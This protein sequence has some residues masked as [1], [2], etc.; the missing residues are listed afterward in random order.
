MKPFR[1][2]YVGNESFIKR[3]EDVATFLRRNPDAKEVEGMTILLENDEVIAVSDDKVEEYTKSHKGVVPFSEDYYAKHNPKEYKNEME[4]RE[5]KQAWMDEYG[6]SSVEH[7][8]Y[9]DVENARQQAGEEL[10]RQQGRYMYDATTGTGKY[11]SE[12]RFLAGLQKGFGV[13][14]NKFYSAG[15][16]PLGAVFGIAGNYVDSREENSWD[17]ATI[18]QR[19]EI[20]NS[21]NDLSLGEMF[22]PR[23]RL[24]LQAGYN[25]RMR[26]EEGFLG[27]AIGQTIENAAVMALTRQLSAGAAHVG[28][29]G[30]GAILAGKAAEKGKVLSSAWQGAKNA[31]ALGKIGQWVSQQIGLYETFNRASQGR[32]WIEISDRKDLD[33]IDKELIKQAKGWNEQLTEMVEI[34]SINKLERTLG[35]TA[36][37]KG[38]LNKIKGYVGSGL[39]SSITNSMQ[40]FLAQTVE[41]VI[42]RYWKGDIK[43]WEEIK[44]NINEA[45]QIGGIS[46]GS[47]NVV[48]GAIGT[49]QR[50][51]MTEIHIGKDGTGI[52]ARGMTAENAEKYQS[53]AMSYIRGEYVASTPE[54]NA[55]I[56]NLYYDP[57]YVDFAQ[58]NIENKDFNTEMVNEKYARILAMS[59]FGGYAGNQG[60]AIVDLNR[61]LENYKGGIDDE[62]YKT[63]SENISQLEKTLAQE[64]SDGLETKGAEYA[65]LN[66][67][68]MELLAGKLIESTGLTAEDMTKSVDEILAMS[69][70]ISREDVLE[71]MNTML[72][73]SDIAL[74]DFKGLPTRYM[75]AEETYR[76]S[77]LT[78]IAKSLIASQYGNDSEFSV[79]LTEDGEFES[80]EDVGDES[81]VEMT[82]AVSDEPIM[83]SVTAVNDWDVREDVVTELT[84][85]LSGLLI[86]EIY[87]TLREKLENG[88]ITDAEYVSL[89]ESEYKRAYESEEIDKK[90]YNKIKKIINEY[91]K[92][93]EAR[94]AKADS[95][96]QTADSDVAESPA[97]EYVSDEVTEATSDT[98]ETEAPVLSVKDQ[99]KA[100]TQEQNDIKTRK[101]ALQD[102]IKRVEN[103]MSSDDAKILMQEGIENNGKD[104]THALVKRIKNHIKDL[105]E[106]HNQLNREKGSLREAGK[107]N[108]SQQVVD[109]RQSTVD[110]TATESPVVAE[111]TTETPVETPK[112]QKPKPKPKPKSTS[113][114]TDT[115]ETEKTLKHFEDWI[116]T[117]KKKMSKEDYNDFVD[118]LKD[119]RS[120]LDI[121]KNTQDANVKTLQEKALDSALKVINTVMDNMKFDTDSGEQSQATADSRQQTADSNVTESPVVAD[122]P[123]VTPPVE[124]PKTT[125]QKPKQK[126]KAKADSGQQQTVDPNETTAQKKKRLQ[127]WKKT[128]TSG[129]VKTGS[130]DFL[131]RGEINKDLKAMGIKVT[132]N[133]STQQLQEMIDNKLV[134]IENELKSITEQSK[135]AKVTEPK[136]ILN[137]QQKGEVN[138]AK[139]VLQR[140]K[141]FLKERNLDAEYEYD[142]EGLED[143]I[144]KLEDAKA[145]DDIE[146]MIDSLDIEVSNA[147]KIM[148]ENENRRYAMRKG[149]NKVFNESLVSQM[150]FVEDIEG[151]SVLSVLN[152]FVTGFGLQ[153][154]VFDN[155][156]GVD[157]VYGRDNRT[158]YIYKNA[159]NP[160]AWVAKHE[161]GHSIAEF[162]ELN[163]LFKDSPM[164][165]DYHK[166]HFDSVFKLYTGVN[167]RNDGG[168]YLVRDQFRSEDWTR[169]YVN[170]EVWGNFLGD[171]IKRQSFWDYI[172]SQDKNLFVRTWLWAK[173][174]LDVMGDLVK[175]VFKF[176][177]N[178]VKFA[179]EVRKLE[180]VLDTAARKSQRKYGKGIMFSLSPTSNEKARR[181]A[182]VMALGDS[183]AFIDILRKPKDARTKKPY[184]ANVNRTPM[185]N[186]KEYAMSNFRYK[187]NTLTGE[188]KGHIDNHKVYKVAD[189]GMTF[190]FDER[191]LKETSGQSKQYKLDSIFH[192]PTIC[193]GSVYLGSREN[194]KKSE[195]P[196]V[197]RYEY[198][199]NQVLINKGKNKG[200]YLVRLC[201]EV[202][203]NTAL[204]GSIEEQTYF[205][206]YDMYNVTE[207]KDSESHPITGDK[208]PASGDTNSLS[209]IKKTKLAQFCQDF[210]LDNT[211]DTT[212]ES[213]ALPK[214]TKTKEERLMARID[215]AFDTNKEV[216]TRVK[217]LLK[218]IVGDDKGKKMYERLFE[219]MPIE[220]MHDLA[221]AFVKNDFNREEYK[222]IKDSGFLISSI[223]NRMMAEALAKVALDILDDTSL[224]DDDRN[225][226]FKKTYEKVRHYVYLYDSSVTQAGRLLRASRESVDLN[227]ELDKLNEAMKKIGGMNIM[228]VTD[229]EVNELVSRHKRGKKI[230]NQ[231]KTIPYVTVWDFLNS[232]LY[233]SLLSGITTT[234]RNVVGNT[235]MM[236]MDGILETVTDLVNTGHTTGAKG[237]GTGLKS[238][239]REGVSEFLKAFREVA[240]PSIVSE[241]DRDKFES[242]MRN[243]SK[244]HPSLRKLY[245]ALN[246]TGKVM[247]AQ[248]KP[249]KHATRDSMVHRISLSLSHNAELM[250]M[251]YG[252]GVT[253]QQA[254]EKLL[255]EPPKRVMQYAVEQAAYATFNGEPDMA[256][257][258]LYRFFVDLR[259]GL[260]SM[261]S[262]NKAWD[263]ARQSFSMVSRFVLP[264]MKIAASLSNLAIDF[265]PGFGHLQMWGR[266]VGQTKEMN[267][268]IANIN[269]QRIAKE[270]KAKQVELVKHLYKRK[271]DKEIVKMYANL[272]MFLG[273]MLYGWLGKG[274]TG[275]G[276]KDKREREQLRMLGWRPYSIK[277]GGKWISYQNIPMVNGYLTMVGDLTDGS[278]SEQLKDE[279]LGMAVMKGLGLVFMS[280]V[281]M[282][283]TNS[284]MQGALNLFEQ[285]TRRDVNGVDSWVSSTLGNMTPVAGMN[286]WRNVHDIINP[287]AK[288]PNGVWQGYVN[289]MRAVMFMTKTFDEIPSRINIFGEEAIRGNLSSDFLG[290]V[291]WLAGFGPNYA[292]IQDPRE[293]EAVKSLVMDLGIIMP[294]TNGRVKVD[295]AYLKDPQ[296]IEVFLKAR[297]KKFK[298]M[299]DESLRSSYGINKDIAKAKAGDKGAEDR[300]RQTLTKMGVRA[301]VA[302]KDAVLKW[303]RGKR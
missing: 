130:I 268:E 93:L 169:D 31:P 269:K 24:A 297:G 276:P 95:G 32:E 173:W 17:P 117:N 293:R 143:A 303:R 165:R 57:D 133:T 98:T 92:D 63:I 75:N 73:Y 13:I 149:G 226:K 231:M 232:N 10:S 159:E 282:M 51:G 112:K 43:S 229:G 88:D 256:M 202:R 287:T 239:W 8:I 77:K 102:I 49:P 34:G 209:S 176:D 2:F 135:K 199:V 258:I 181:K 275:G 4:A 81:E 192:L 30:K 139:D 271:R 166:E 259:L 242:R 206:R 115:S 50:R 188:A 157:G 223:A 191:G 252:K 111:S 70:D 90:E 14:G 39:M 249:F 60:Q 33:A 99:I 126:P 288:Q 67:E 224:T 216:E 106:Q 45:W 280:Q 195:K 83:E 29:M 240:H 178:A 218:D 187:D 76:S 230:E 44:N 53:I 214:K 291:S 227:I 61:L 142:V 54:N 254:Y 175:S 136:S 241:V 58:K 156:L 265:T 19:A 37:R 244:I 154:K 253:Q 18:I 145:T 255:A 113:Q 183:N 186:A 197:V 285:I 6:K 47:S 107:V 116:K 74:R 278:L 274:I 79:T 152:D 122:T 41:E 213:Y 174:K 160:L 3:D 146:D 289:S 22:H 277:V 211:T 138:E 283:L 65:K 80:A 72:T 193:G 82:E 228:E 147:S 85:D 66:R 124:T 222:K 182:K 109:S 203:N 279:S 153:L 234:G 26:E 144:K 194:N 125:P 298:A 301:N 225:E 62:T 7:D 137:E 260:E 114:V 108:S 208:S 233:N 219:R 266:M 118:S 168:Q 207:K 238:G 246:I 261:D 273:A 16:G 295:D 248:D 272:V 119:A 170:E 128:L 27:F 103:K 101:K 180:N 86:D 97:T 35:R 121:M 299:F 264:F 36:L 163:E 205:H 215:R 69:Q 9:Q 104:I 129:T 140:F 171:N 155:N 245:N 236:V 110:S 201:F 217:K 294:V 40:E 20:P 204:D 243:L 270:D 105:Q 68:Y 200:E 220:D 162:V 87:T 286:L 177:K 56:N 212:S 250:E 179:W 190:M 235:I 184:K 78:K 5:K 21:Y 185:Q 120:M 198:Y 25:E 161:W 237:Y 94:K 12:N 284:F 290:T 167:F 172:A 134:E 302:G 296:E 100:K 150:T 64:K 151:D 158:V 11:A 123:E 46:G 221:E 96:Q 281:D 71:I 28:A 196:N 267:T 251:L 292:Q 164:F 210:S 38:L 15:F 300:I 127:D 132:P 131:S 52:F 141:K 1:W 42:D 48:L 148:R 263:H 189:T 247:G 55:I 89:M 91:K 257:G 84:E 23:N 59:Q 262:G